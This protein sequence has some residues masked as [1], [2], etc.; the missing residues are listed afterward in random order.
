MAWGKGVW[1]SFGAT[2][3]FRDT[4]F[5][6]IRGM[7]VL[8][9]PNGSGKSTLI[10]ML[11]GLIKP[12]KGSLWIDRSLTIGVLLEDN[13]FPRSTRIWDIINY[14]RTIK[15]SGEDRELYDL[16]DLLGIKN[17]INKK[18]SELSA[19]LIK[20]AMLLQALLGEP[21]LLVLDE[22]FANLDP[23]SRILLASMLNTMRDRGVNMI[24]AT[25]IISILQPDNIYTISN[26]KVL[27]PYRLPR[28]RL[29]TAINPKSGEVLELNP[30]E[31]V[32]AYS[33][34]YIILDG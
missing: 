17:Y 20:R 18:L 24:I 5:C 15:K 30:S 10:K 2:I 28:G 34:G 33:E 26:Y 27:G 7:S 11:L 21:E 1:K 16:I 6:F 19:G 25:H 29:V 8:W 3:V 4:D 22:P 23:A 31:A 9:A 32:K 14:A 12:D 13:P